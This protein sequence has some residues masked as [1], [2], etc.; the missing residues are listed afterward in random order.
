MLMKSNPTINIETIN[1]DNCIED[2][3]RQLAYGLPECEHNQLFIAYIPLCN[4]G[5]ELILDEETIQN[6]FR[7]RIGSQKSPVKFNF[8]GRQ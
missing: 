8:I 1:I 4:L 5:E 2:S 3:I 7:T 6:F